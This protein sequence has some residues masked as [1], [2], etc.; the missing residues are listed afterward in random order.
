M[1]FYAKGGSAFGGKIQNYLR[2]CEPKTTTKLGFE[3]ASLVLSKPVGFWVNAPTK[4]SY[5]SHLVIASPAARLDAAILQIFCHCEPK[6]KQS[7]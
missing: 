1:K 4:Q 2:H 5:N 7:Y 3:Q 6:A